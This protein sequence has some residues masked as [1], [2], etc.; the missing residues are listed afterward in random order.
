MEIPERAQHFPPGA[1]QH[2]ILRVDVCIHPGLNFKDFDPAVVLI[3]HPILDHRFVIIGQDIFAESPPARLQILHTE[4][5]Y[6]SANAAIA[7]S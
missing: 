5:E 7:A 2:G 4:V 1:K 3:G 6:E